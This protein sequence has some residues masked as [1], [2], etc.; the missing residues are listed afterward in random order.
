RFRWY[1]GR[2]HPI[3]P[4]TPRLLLRQWRDADREPFA[5][6]NADPRVMEHFPNPLTREES[7]A[8][9]DRARAAIDLRGWGMWAVERREDGRFLGFVG[10]TAVR[11]EIPFAPAIEIGWRM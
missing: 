7:D 5:A 1:T 3:E 6:M 2:P 10:L 8:L 9:V 11:D 4:A